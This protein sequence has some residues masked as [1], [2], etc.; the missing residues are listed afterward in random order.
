MK[1]IF[2]ACF[3]II[4]PNYADAC[5]YRA[6]SIEE[7]YKNSTYVYTAWVTGIQLPDFER[8]KES[9]I[10]QE[11]DEQLIVVGYETEKLFLLPIKKYKGKRSPKEVLSGYCWNGAVELKDKAIFFVSKYDGEYSSF[12]IPESNKEYFTKSLAIIEQLTRKSSR[13]R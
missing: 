6:Q 8:Q 10:N 12:A 3:F 7:R 11:V 4:Y 9:E 1:K 2:L 5:R 13:T